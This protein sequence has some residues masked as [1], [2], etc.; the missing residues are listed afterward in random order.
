[1][2]FCTA[3]MRKKKIKANFMNHNIAGLLVKN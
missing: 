2:M 3:Y 1:M